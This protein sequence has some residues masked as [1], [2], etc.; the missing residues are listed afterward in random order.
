MDQALRDEIRNTLLSRHAYTHHP[1][2]AESFLQMVRHALSL[3]K[4]SR[5]SSPEFSSGFLLLASCMYADELCFCRIHGKTTNQEQ[6]RA[7]ARRLMAEIPVMVAI[8]YPL[9]IRASGI[10]ELLRLFR[11]SRDLSKAR[12]L[13]DASRYVSYARANEHLVRQVAKAI[14]TT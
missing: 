3:P 12:I 6:R 9:P 14:T 2:Y 5:L 1:A 10:P 4:I 8:V 7:S 11:S 13:L